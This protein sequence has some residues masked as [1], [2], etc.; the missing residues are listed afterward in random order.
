MNNVDIS[1][2]FDITKYFNTLLNESGLNVCKSLNRYGNQLE[3]SYYNDVKEI[4]ID[5]DRYDDIPDEIH[6]I[7]AWG[8]NISEMDCIALNHENYKEKIDELVQWFIS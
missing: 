8:Y 3:T 6:V 4:H 2:F 1:L 5:Y 7:S